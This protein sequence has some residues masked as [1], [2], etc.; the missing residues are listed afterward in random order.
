MVGRYDEK[1]LKI[2][3]AKR[4]T[5]TLAE[6]ARAT[7]LGIPEAEKR[8]RYLEETGEAHKTVG[9]YISPKIFTDKTAE[10]NCAEQA[11]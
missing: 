3:D 6:I 9:G 1:I 11:A 8:L 10:E 4:R 2:L 5:Y 7:G